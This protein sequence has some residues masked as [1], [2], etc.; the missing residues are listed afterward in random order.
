MDKK[1]EKKHKKELKRNVI[2]KTRVAGVKNKKISDQKIIEDLTVKSNGK[3]S[4]DDIKQMISSIMA[5]E[6][7]EI[8]VAFEAVLSAIKMFSNGQDVPEITDEEVKKLKEGYEDFIKRNEEGT[9]ILFN[10]LDQPNKQIAPITF[11]DKYGRPIIRPEDN[12]NRIIVP[13]N[14][15]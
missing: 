11:L 15:K 3:F 9:G 8:E 13:K 14:M 7:C 10:D 12:R 6:D 1:A 4:E 2:R 5:Q